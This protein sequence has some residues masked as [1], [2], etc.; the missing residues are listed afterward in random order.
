M[1]EAA[2]ALAA[3]QRLADDV[4]FPSALATEAAGQVPASHLDRLAEAGLYGVVG[5]PG[6]GG[7]GGGLAEQSEAAETLAAGCLAT[8]FVWAQHH[9]LVRAMA[10]VAPAALRDAWLGPLCRGDRRAGVA[11]PGLLPGPSRLEARR[12]EGG[13][14]LDGSAPWVTGWGLID[15]V[16]VA[17]TGPGG[18][19]VWLVV[20]A[21]DRPGLAAHR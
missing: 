4:L 9:R 17:A 16:Y 11:L 2:G 13:W 6:D 21:V 14:I 7:L 15:V 18:A 10:T 20:D 19:V 5:P 1:T 12:T 8:T 3:A